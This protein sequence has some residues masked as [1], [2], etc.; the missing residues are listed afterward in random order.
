MI[1]LSIA[2]LSFLAIAL[3]YIVVFYF[4]LLV[5]VSASVGSTTEVLMPSVSPR[6]VVA[7]AYT[8]RVEETD[9]TPCQT[10]LGPKVDICELAKTEQ[11][12]ATWLY[13]LKTKIQVG[14]YKCLVVDRPA[15]KNAHIVDILMGTV[16]EA[17]DF[18]RRTLPVW[19]IHR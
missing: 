9:A 4:F 10:A 6:M 3:L 1:K 16:A 5:I 19:V 2:L 7:T 18:G 8:L 14:N 17:I 15:L 11:L 13:P 12:C